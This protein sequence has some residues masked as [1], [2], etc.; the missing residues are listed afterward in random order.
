MTPPDELFAVQLRGAGTATFQVAQVA[1]VE[2]GLYEQVQLK[3]VFE[4]Q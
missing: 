4:P 2:S 1:G 3:Y